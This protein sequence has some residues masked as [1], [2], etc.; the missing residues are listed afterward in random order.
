MSSL[1]EAEGRNE[2]RVVV[3]RGPDP[4]IAVPVRIILRRHVP[5]LLPDVRPHLVEL[6]VATGEVPHRPIEQ[7]VARLPDADEEAENRVAVDSG[8][9]LGA[10]DGASFGER[11]DHLDLLGGLELV[12]GYYCLPIIA[13]RQGGGVAFLSD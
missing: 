9:A 2:P 10:P 11:G 4:E 13:P 5:L 7:D 8:H 3:D 1:S 12:H 6:D